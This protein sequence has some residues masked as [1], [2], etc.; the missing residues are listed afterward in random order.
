MLETV[1]PGRYDTE[2]MYWSVYNS[3]SLEPNGPT[4]EEIAEEA[5]LW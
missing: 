1:M 5:G 2:R 4:L 3:Y